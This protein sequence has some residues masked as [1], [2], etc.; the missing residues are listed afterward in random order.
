MHFRRL[1]VKYWFNLALLI[2][3]PLRDI[4]GYR[5]MS[6]A[7]TA[8][9]NILRYGYTNTQNYNNNNKY[10]ELK[11]IYEANNLEFWFPSEQIRHE[12]IASGQYKPS[13]PLPIDV[14][15]FY[16]SK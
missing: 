1:K 15:V 12:A 14:D 8:Q 6:P 7:S 4:N 2:L 13:N 11:T 9:E 10:K 5:Y 3:I 16:P